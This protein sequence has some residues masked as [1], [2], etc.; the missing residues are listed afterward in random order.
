MTRYRRYKSAPEFS[1]GSLLFKKVPMP[2]EPIT[3]EQLIEI[4]D[5]VTALGV[6]QDLFD[7]ILG[8]KY[9]VTKAGYLNKQCAAQ[10]IDDL[11][12]SYIPN[13][14]DT[15]WIGPRPK[16][17]KNERNNAQA[18]KADTRPAPAGEAD[19]RAV[20]PDAP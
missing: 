15:Y 9:S 14:E 13:K 11:L 7:Y 6:G 19:G 10:F 8:A 17:I 20:S 4:W 12:N 18:D 1:T 2:G 16:E 5:V 3:R